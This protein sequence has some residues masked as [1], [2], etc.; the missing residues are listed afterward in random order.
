[1]HA[2]LLATNSSQSFA[3]SAHDPDIRFARALVHTAI[4]FA[5]N[6]SPATRLART[7]RHNSKEAAR[8]RFE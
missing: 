2:R 8:S 6:R 7:S 4:E 5:A 3:D 1:M